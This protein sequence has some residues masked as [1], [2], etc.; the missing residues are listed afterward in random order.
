MGA[1]LL[2]AAVAVCA[3]TGDR[4]IFDEIGRDLRELN[5]I[6]GLKI[7]HKVPFDLISKDQVNEFL[8]DRIKKKRTPRICASRR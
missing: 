1:Y 4:A 2:L 7:H 6:T 5:Q 8:K 3:E